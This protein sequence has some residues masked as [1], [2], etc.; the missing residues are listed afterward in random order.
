MAP[1][2]FPP[3]ID[4]DHISRIPSGDLATFTVQIFPDITPVHCLTVSIFLRFFRGV[5]GFVRHW[6]PQVPTISY[7]QWLI[8]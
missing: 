7:P 5:V 4:R 8:L 6:V 3:D 2:P 1:P